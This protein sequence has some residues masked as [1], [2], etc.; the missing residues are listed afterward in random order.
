[1]DNV[2]HIENLYWLLFYSNTYDHI[3]ILDERQ[4]QDNHDKK[5]IFYFRIYIFIKGSHM[6]KSALL[7]I[8]SSNIFRF[9]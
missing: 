8:F 1:M 5:A 3:L 4:K 9:N 7:I 6:M 2:P